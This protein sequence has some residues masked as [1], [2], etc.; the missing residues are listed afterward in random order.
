MASHPE[1]RAAY[2]AA[3]NTIDTSALKVETSSTINLISESS[4]LPIHV[5]NTYDYP[6]NVT[7]T[8]T[9]PDRR[10]HALEPA[11]ATIPAHSTTH[12]TIPVEAW[13]SG[14][15]DVDVAITDS[16]GLTLGKSSTVHVRVRANWENTGTVVVAL[17]IGTL[18]IFG[19]IKSIRNGRRS[20][21]VDPQ[22]ASHA[23]HQAS[24]TAS[25]PLSQN[26]E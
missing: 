4:S 11:N 10:L 6:V 24:A 15:L 12:V 1:A 16:S 3:L 19:V 7:V 21:P 23:I 17:L 25:K 13:G 9:A 8:L 20:E 26:S 5:T 14:N 22:L 18:F 2:A